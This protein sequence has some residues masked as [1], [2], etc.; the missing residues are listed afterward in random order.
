MTSHYSHPTGTLTADLALAWEAIEAGT[1]DQDAR[2]WDLRLWVEYLL[3]NGMSH[4]YL[5]RKDPAEKLSIL[6]AFA[7][8]VCTGDLGM[9][10]RVQLGSVSTAL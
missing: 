8:K 4:R 9:G 2:F 7:A 6:L 10:A 5:R 3:A 1:V